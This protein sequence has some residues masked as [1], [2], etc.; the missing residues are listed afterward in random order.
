MIHF[1]Q[2]AGLTAFITMAVLTF[3]DASLAAGFYLAEVGSPGSLGTAGVANVTNN[4]G[5]DASWTNPAGLTGIAP[6]H[7]AGAGLQ[8]AVPQVKFNV[9]SIDSAGP[10]PSGG[11]NGGNAGIVAPIPSL[12]VVGPQLGK[13]RV[14]L[15][16]TAPLGGGLNYGNSFAGRYATEKTELSGVGITPS[17]GYQLTDKLSIGAGASIIYTK[18]NQRIAIRQPAAAGDATLRF[19]DLTDWGVQGIVGLNYHVNE[20]ILFGMV[21]R[22]KMDT[23]LEGDVRVNNLTLPV[24]TPS[25]I[26]ID[27]TNPQWL[28]AGLRISA[29]D[30]TTIF[31]NAGWQ[32]WSKFSNNKLGFDERVTVIDRN[33]QDTW[34]AGI[35]MSH[36]LQSDTLLSFGVSYDSSPV[37]DQDR[38]FDLPVGRIWKLSA[39]YLWQAKENLSVSVGATV[40]LM[41]DTPIDQTSQGVRVQGNYS[42]NGFALLGGHL[43]YD[44]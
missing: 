30:A 31:F 13:A 18:F 6:G 26:R 14:G 7:H 16:I 37:N 44:Y 21:Y 4:H 41:G 39:G 8:V 3:S 2:P 19:Q 42:R 10:V 27:W 12:F 29:S 23:K 28:E 25:K 32:Q 33:W 11:G 17:V 34:H 5:V 36:K 20:R 15:A 40:Y 22:S 1:R 35:A 43:R 38:T 24:R 9:N